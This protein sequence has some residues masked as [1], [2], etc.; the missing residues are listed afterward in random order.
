VAVLGAAGGIG[1]PLSLL[2]KSVDHITEL[3]LYDLVNTPGVAADLAHIP[4]RAKVRAPRVPRAARAP[5][6]AARP[7]GGAAPAPARASAQAPQRTRSLTTCSRHPPLPTHTRARRSRAT[8]APT[9]CRR[10]WRARTW[11]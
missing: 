10:R 11:S 1:Q 3:R 8:R 4:T 7:C 5:P 2:L 6:V 9:S